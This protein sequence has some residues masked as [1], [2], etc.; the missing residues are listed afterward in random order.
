MVTIKRVDVLSAM[1]VGALLN[2]VTV[3]VISVLFFACNSFAFSAINTSIS[4][5]NAQTGGS[6][7]F[8]SSA[9]ATASLAGCLI[10]YVILI[11]A[12]T[13]IGAIMGAMY[14]FFYNIISNWTG[15]IR[16]ELD[17]PSLQMSEKRKLESGDE[18]RF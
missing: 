13:I 17:T 3:T 9:F 15:G 2:A 1:K 5:L 4:Q 6:G 11:V 14:A 7:G 16:V 8:N 12:A 10:S 18:F